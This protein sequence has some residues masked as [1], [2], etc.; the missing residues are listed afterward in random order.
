MS[1]FPSK[2]QLDNVLGVLLGVELRNVQMALENNSQ[3]KIF[4]KNNVDCF[5]ND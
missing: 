5:K 2:R 1:T 4:C 3:K